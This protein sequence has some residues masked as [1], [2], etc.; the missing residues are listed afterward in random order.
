M[1]PNDRREDSI[2]ELY[3]MDSL[4]SATT[5]LRPPN[6]PS[7]PLPA[8]S[9]RQSCPCQPQEASQTTAAIPGCSGTAL[10]KVVSQSLDMG[11]R[12]IALMFSLRVFEA[13]VSCNRMAGGSSEKK[14]KEKAVA[15]RGTANLGASRCPQFA[16]GGLWR[17]R[18]R[19]GTW[20]CPGRRAHGG[21][22]PG[23][24]PSW[25]TLTCMYLANQCIHLKRASVF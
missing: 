19:T 6:A 11:S 9:S 14:V 2:Q 8:L 12:I 23:C 16:A 24:P 1:G 18:N 17:S 4:L 22:P 3:P 25:V 10:K 5:L 21:L 20:C 7:P 15:K 13:R